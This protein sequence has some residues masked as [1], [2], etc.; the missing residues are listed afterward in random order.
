MSADSS[1]SR[2]RKATDA[3]KRGAEVAANGIYQATDFVARNDGRIA[4]GAQAVTG[5]V[6]SGLDKAGRGLASASR[7]TSQVL[8]D[9]ADFA[10]DRLRE[11][12]TGSGT[13]GPAR[14]AL[15][16]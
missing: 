16:C 9:N 10:A 15:G 11:A 4:D 5:A 14:K 7:R 3:V 12:I 8:H 1:D 13:A 2:T 6:G